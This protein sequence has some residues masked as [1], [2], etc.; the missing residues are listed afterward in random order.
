MKVN[1]GISELVSNT[2]AAAVI[3]RLSL[4]DDFSWSLRCFD[5]IVDVHFAVKVLNQVGNVVFVE[6]TQN[7]AV[8]SQALS[9]LLQVLDCVGVSSKATAQLLQH[10][11]DLQWSMSH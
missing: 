1:H 5:G 4:V 10:F 6:C 9:H 7:A 2:L 3:R 8:G 11:S